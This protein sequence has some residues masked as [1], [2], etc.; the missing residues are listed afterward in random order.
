MVCF[1]IKSAWA[2]FMLGAL[3]KQRFVTM[4]NMHTIVSPCVWPSLGKTSCQWADAY[5]DTN[6]V[7]WRNHLRPSMVY[8]YFSIES[9]LRCYSWLA[10][11]LLS[12]MLTSACWANSISR[13]PMRF[14]K[15][16]LCMHVWPCRHAGL[17]CLATCTCWR[18]LFF[19]HTSFAIKLVY[20]VAN[21]RAS[22]F[23]I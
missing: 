23:V 5:G 9:Q 7:R 19:H 11:Y 18:R 14:H 2:T 20:K 21:D 8:I 3:Y 15:T 22:V 12:F 16:H 6:K 17:Q 4:H 13:W 10:T 1:C